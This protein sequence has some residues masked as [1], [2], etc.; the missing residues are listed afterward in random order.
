MHTATN[1]L[2]VQRL[3]ELIARKVGIDH[4][5]ATHTGAM[6]AGHWWVHLGVK[7]LANF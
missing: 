2:R 5:N 3:Y 1:A 4:L 6:N 7:R